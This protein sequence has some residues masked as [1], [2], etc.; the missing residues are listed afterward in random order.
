MDK[1]RSD[2]SIEKRPEVKIDKT[3]SI[4]AKED[5]GPATITDQILNIEER[6]GSEGQVIQEQEECGSSERSRSK[7]SVS[8]QSFKKA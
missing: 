3:V 8:V 6:D 2:D 7:I 5:E 4:D 1:T